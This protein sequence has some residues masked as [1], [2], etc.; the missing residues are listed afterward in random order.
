MTPSDA[1]KISKTVDELTRQLTPAL[2]DIGFFEATVDNPLVGKKIGNSF[3]GHAL[4]IAIRAVAMKL[5]LFVTRSWERN[6]N[7]IITF[8]KFAGS[9][10][11]YIESER[12]SKHPDFP[13]NFLQIGM[14]QRRLNALHRYQRC[15]T[16]HPSFIA[17]RRYR[18]EHLAHLLDGQSDI[19][20]RLN[21]EDLIIEDLTY[22]DLLN[23]SN[24]TAVI[25][26]NVLQ[27]WKFE[28]RNPQD[29]IRISRKY[30]L[31]FWNFLPSLS[32]AEKKS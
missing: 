25:I 31:D 26:S 22:K 20:K 13:E 1:S 3:S 15:F 19:S 30:T 17:A 23:L 16:N 6:G 11:E 18:T 14:V 7:S 10:G 29:A 21:K 24:K 12:K 27:I 5:V 32:D 9:S 8:L 4:D 28:I 2:Y